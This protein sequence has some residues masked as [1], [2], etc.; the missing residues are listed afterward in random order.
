MFARYAAGEATRAATPATGEERLALGAMRGRMFMELMERIAALER[1][2]AGLAPALKRRVA[3]AAD[4]LCGE[5]DSL[6]CATASFLHAGRCDFEKMKEAQ[7]RF[8]AVLSGLPPEVRAQALEGGGQMLGP[9]RAFASGDARLRGLL[10]RSC[11]SRG[12]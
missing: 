6:S 2:N 12:Q 8:D 3:T 1:L 7:Q 9:A 10:R 5:D 11:G 4:G